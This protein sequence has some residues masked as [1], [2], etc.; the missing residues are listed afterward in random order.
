MQ[1][2]RIMPTIARAM[3][4]LCS[5]EIFVDEYFK[6]WQDTHRATDYLY[7]LIQPFFKHWEYMLRKCDY[8]KDLNYIV[9][10][11]RLYSSAGNP[12]ILLREYVEYAD[13]VSSVQEE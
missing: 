7:K 11:R 2:Y 12:Q 8:Q 5:P 6:C 10:C 1:L 4:L 3:P 9:L 13:Q